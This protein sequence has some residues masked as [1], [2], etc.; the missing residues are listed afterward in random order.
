M[1]STQVFNR[2]IIYGKY[3]ELFLKL[4]YGTLKKQ[5]YRYIGAID[6]FER[7]FGNKR[8]VIV[9][10]SPGRCEISGNHTDHQNGCVL[11]ASVTVDVLALASKNDSNII[12][13]ISEG[14]DQISIDISD[15]EI[16]KEE[17]NTSTSLIRGIAAYFK[18]NNY[19]IGGY[20]AYMISDVPKGSGLS[21]SACFEVAIG[22][23]MNVLFNDEKISAIDIAKAG[24]FA[25]NIYFMKPSG[26]MDQTACAIGGM[27]SI[28]FQDVNNPK[29][30]SVDSAVM[31]NNYSLAV[32]NTG[33]SHADL[34]HLYA[35][36]PNEMKEVAAY[37]HKTVLRE[38]NEE[39]FYSSLPELR[40]E[41]SDRAI[42]RAH[43][44]FSEN[45][46]VK[47]QIDALMNKKTSTFIELTRASG[48]SSSIYLENIYPDDSPEERAIPL[49]LAIS[50]LYLGD[51]GAYRI[52]GGGFAGTIL[53][54][55][56]DDMLG[57]YISKM[58]EIF[59]ENCCYRLRIRHFGGYCI[60]K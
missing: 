54:I 43:H 10:S 55:V 7:K 19:D 8:D 21:S 29:I 25:E 32:V 34:S 6:S 52:H 40:S 24:K 35:S 53:S 58:E 48:R 33:D 50:E 59:G 56:P 23:I 9:I 12:N 15:L 4:Y 60:A 28:D 26:F 42:L 44:F 31:D 1:P 20:D 14:Y 2:D 41:V 57:G 49:A 5:K 39:D 11:A 51:K 36:I 30:I 13:I 3:D 46:R 16:H 45:L 27:I 37:F 22:T 17:A 47:A 38:V 18:K